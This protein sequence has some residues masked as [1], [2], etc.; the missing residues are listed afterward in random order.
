MAETLRDQQLRMTRYIRDPQAN[1]PPP[2]I[3]ARRL[4]V[5]R[6]LFFGNLQSLLAGNFPVL[7]ASLAR[8][9]WQALTE[10]FYAAFRCQTPLF[11]EV[12]GE[13]VEY[14][15]ERTDQPGWV[16]EL[17]HYEFIETALLLSDDAEPPHDPH[18]DLL[19]GVPLL[20]S[21][22]VPLAYAWPVSHIGPEHLPSHA[23]AEP[24]LLLARRDTDLKVYFSRLAPLAH[25]L[26]VSLQ[27]WQLTGRQ[28]LTAL[29]EIAGVEA[30]A[31]EA[32]GIALLRS[33]KEQGVVLG[34]RPNCTTPR[35]PP[36]HR[37]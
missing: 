33:L 4:A 26:L 6:K 25:A 28:H 37:P 11:T 17:A 32:Q 1:E 9:Q 5:Y 10:D 2:G 27:Q 14:L 7:H 36:L 16:A 22:A 24:T 21:L 31:I 18:G 15:E 12:A 8:E 30:A 23:P 20:S 19:D 34:T 3:E 13:F 35:R 29:A